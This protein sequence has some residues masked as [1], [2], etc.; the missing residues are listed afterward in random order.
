M[1]RLTG[2]AWVDWLIILGALVAALSTIWYKA[3]RPLISGLQRLRRFFD[4]VENLFDMGEELAPEVRNSL[5]A[6]QAKLVEGHDEIMDLL[7]KTNDRIDAHMDAEEASL[8][9]LVGRLAAIETAV[10]A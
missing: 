10:T 4:K 5:F 6:T 8:A 2:I 7:G 1:P 3:L 9:Q